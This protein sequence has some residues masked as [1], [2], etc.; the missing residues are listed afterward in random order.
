MTAPAS[1]GPVMVIGTS[2]ARRVELLKSHFAGGVHREFIALP[3]DIDEKAWRSPDPFELTKLIARAKMQAV[4]EKL[5]DAHPHLKHGVVVTFDQVVVKDGEVREKPESAEE[6]RRFLKSYSNSHVGTVAAYVV[7]SLDT[8]KLTVGENETDT[9]FSAYGDDVVERVL[10]RGACM[11]TA[12]AFV[13]ED[14]DISRHVVRNVGTFEAVQG[15]D[16]IVLERLMKQ[17]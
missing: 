10:A 14:E 3:P 4:L 16:P 13:V 1:R 7:Y 9:Y 15:V 2:S 5:K 17:E 11:H 12:G 6:A 8:G